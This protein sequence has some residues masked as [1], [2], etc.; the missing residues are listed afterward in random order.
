MLDPMFDPAEILPDQIRPLSRREYERMVEQG[1]FVGEPIELL[2]GLLVTMSPQ[3]N[4]HRDVC[5]WLAQRIILAIG[6]MRLRVSCAMP[7]AADD[8]SE[9][10]PD[11][12]IADRG[13]EPSQHP[14]GALLVIE[15]AYSSHRRDRGVKLQIYARAGIPE[16]WIVDLSQNV[17]EVYTEPSGDRYAHMQTLRDGDVL[18][19]TRLPSIR[20]PV[21]EIPR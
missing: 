9:P 14:D 13:Y 20:I 3:G 15:V 12:L 4:R 8:W 7:F 6:D 21:S 5:S 17:V 11:V 18:A 1:F 10:E 19:P 2:R 16:Y